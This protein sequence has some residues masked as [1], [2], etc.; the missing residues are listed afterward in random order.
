MILRS[1]V[2]IN[3]YHYVKSENNLFVYPEPEASQ[4]NNQVGLKKYN[5]I[6]I[7]IVMNFVMPKAAAILKLL[8]KKQPQCI[9]QKLEP[10]FVATLQIHDN[11]CFE[12]HK[13][14][15]IIKCQNH[16]HLSNIDCLMA[17]TACL[18]CFISN[19]NGHSKK[20]RKK[21]GTSSGH[22]TNLK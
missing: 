9:Q 1:L 22:T 19:V 13:T 20:N 6:Q 15:I 21:C 18:V 3:T 17:H 4:L 12:F 2:N 10:R 8:L 16:R 14:H 5:H 7:M 11:N